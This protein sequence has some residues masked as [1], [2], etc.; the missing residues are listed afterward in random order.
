MTYY[1]YY[2]SKG[3]C[4]RCKK[5]ASDKN[6]VHCAIC[7]AEIKYISEVKKI[8]F[9]RRDLEQF[10]QNKQPLPELMPCKCGGKAEIT[11]VLRQGKRKEMY[12]VACTVCG[13]MK[14]IQMENFGKIGEELYLQRLVEIWNDM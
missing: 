7:R 3:I 1:D 11:K 14:S 4:P 10:L 2:K 8:K 5:R 9:T 12:Y 6:S 13:K